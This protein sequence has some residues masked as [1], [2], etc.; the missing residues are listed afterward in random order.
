MVLQIF[1]ICGL[2]HKLNTNRF[3]YNFI[4]ICCMFPVGYFAAFPFDRKISLASKVLPAKMPLAPH[5]K[6]FL[7]AHRVNKPGSVFF[8]AK[9][10]ALRNSS[11]QSHPKRL[12]PFSERRLRS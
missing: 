8:I 6:P 1:Q 11:A 2:E 12:D 9:A 7:L 3:V 5:A 4:G 10:I